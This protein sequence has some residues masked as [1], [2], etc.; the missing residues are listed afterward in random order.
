MIKPSEILK[1]YTLEEYSRFDINKSNHSYNYIVENLKSIEELNANDLEKYYLEHVKAGSLIENP[2]DKEERKQLIEKINKYQSQT[3]NKFYLIL[4]QNMYSRYNVVSAIKDSL[5]KVNISFQESFENEITQSN[6]SYKLNENA[7]Q[8]LDCLFRYYLNL[9]SVMSHDTSYHFPVGIKHIL[10]RDK[11]DRDYYT[12]FAEESRHLGLYY[13][14]SSICCPYFYN[15]NPNKDFIIME[16]SNIAATAEEIVDIASGKKFIDIFDNFFKEY[17]WVYRTSIKEEIVNALKAIDYLEQHNLC[18]NETFEALSKLIILYYGSA[19]IFLQNEYLSF[20]MTNNFIQHVL[21]NTEFYTT[22]DDTGK[23]KIISLSEYPRTNDDSDIL[24]Y[25]CVDNQELLNRYIDQKTTTF[26]LKSIEA[27]D[28]GMN[29]GKRELE[30][31]DMQS[32]NFAINKVDAKYKGRF[33]KIKKIYNEVFKVKPAKLKQKINSMYFKKWYGRIPG[34]Y[35]RYGDEAKITENKMKGDPTLILANSAPKY[36]ANLVEQTNKIFNEIISLGN[37][38]VSAGDIQAKVNVVKNWCNTYKIEDPTDPD[39]IETAIKNECT[40]R[41]AQA[42][43]QDNGIYGYTPEGIVENGKF[44]T[45]NHIVTSLFI[46][47]AHEEPEEQ[48]V[49]NIFSKPESILIYAHPEKIAT[50]DEL[51]KKTSASIT[52]NFSDKI[53]SSVVKNLDTGYKNYTRS[54][55]LK[56]KEVDSGDVENASQNKKIY[57]A[58]ENGLED[59]LDIIIDQKARCIQCSGAMYDMLTRVQRLAKMCVASLHEVEAAHSDKR[60]N[61]GVND[62][63]RNATNARLNKINSGNTLENKYHVTGAQGRYL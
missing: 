34:M 28:T 45:A 2:D 39:G 12:H 1:K 44:P 62:S 53:T 17:S 18:K 55:S 52:Q 54:L 26:R 35:Q 8:E 19:E 16:G 57:K 32:Q 43:F 49:S 6:D 20:E 59:G 31:K 10:Y 9:G 40:F 22:S 4:K 61:A 7:K 63:A 48:S 38:I 5:A 46:D 41:I 3:N 14:I 47:N 58:I 21:D 51:F 50:Y 15:S 56:S 27:V 37:K 42:I 36:L 13:N 11:Y 25:Q 30:H 33:E 23:Y 24:Y 29:F 60:M